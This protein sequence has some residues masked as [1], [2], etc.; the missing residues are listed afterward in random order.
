MAQLII[1][2][3]DQDILVVNKPAGIAVQP[4]KTGDPSLSDQAVACNNGKPVYVVHRIDRPVSGIVIFGKNQFAAAHLSQQFSKK[5]AQKTYL[6]VVSRLPEP[7]EGQLIHYFEKKEN[8]NKSKA[9]DTPLPGTVEGRLRYQ[10]IQKS[11]KYFLLSIQLETGRHHQIRA[12]LA[13]IGNPIKGDVKYGARR[14]NTDRS[15]HLHAWR[16]HIQHPVSG[17]DLHFTA[18]PPETDALWRALTNAI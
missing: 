11:E 10:C 18:P 15:V 13:A 4:D 2:Y 1:L 7:T 8:A 9:F 6:A 16:L 17:E 3:Q 14:S 5:T 12:Q